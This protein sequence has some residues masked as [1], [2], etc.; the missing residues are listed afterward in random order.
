VGASPRVEI[1]RV[2]PPSKGRA[3]SQAFDIDKLFN[4]AG[5]EVARHHRAFSQRWEIP[6]RRKKITTFWGRQGYCP[7]FD[8]PCR[9]PG[10]QVLGKDFYCQDPSTL[11]DQT[12][13][14]YD[15]YFRLS[16]IWLTLLV[17]GL[18]FA[19]LK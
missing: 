5:A 13:D 3:L 12:M 11:H 8:P 15:L 16:L 19:L 4:F 9:R 1:Y 17:V 2:K 6:L 18:T 10:R 14:R 7:V